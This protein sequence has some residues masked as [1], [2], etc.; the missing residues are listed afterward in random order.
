VKRV[1]AVV[2]LIALVA[3][4]V[5][6]VALFITPAK[7][8]SSAAGKTYDGSQIYE[9]NCQVCHGAAGAGGSGPQLAG[10]RVTQ[11]FPTVA[12]EIAFVESGRG[13]MPPWKGRLN[14]AEIKAVVDYTRSL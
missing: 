7:K 3:A 13:G 14:D 4:G 9:A 10:G 12:D 6:V 8:E 1:V 11:D 2:E 5:F